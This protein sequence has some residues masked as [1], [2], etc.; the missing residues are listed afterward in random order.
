MPTLTI[1]LFVVQGLCFL[2]WAGLSFRALFQIRAIAADRTGRMWPEPVAFLSAVGPWLRNPA[3][4]GA[5]WLWL[6]AL[7]GVIGGAA[8]IARVPGVTE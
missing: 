6:T 2:I 1:L 8:L 5:A 4:R 7:V 3:N